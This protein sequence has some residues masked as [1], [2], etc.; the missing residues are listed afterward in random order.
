M[1]CSVLMTSA[2]VSGWD[3]P[4]QRAIQPGHL[5]HLLARALRNFRFVTQ[6]PELSGE[7]MA[8]SYAEGIQLDSR[9]CAE[10]SQQ[11]KA[12]GP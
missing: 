8:P 6:R 4:V 3:T 11:S 12:A 5:R 1:Q 10:E 2:V 7:G 9:H